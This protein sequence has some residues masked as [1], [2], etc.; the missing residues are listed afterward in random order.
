MWTCLERA[1]AKGPDDVGAAYVR[2]K[3]LGPEL[4]EVIEASVDPSAAISRNGRDM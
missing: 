3:L 4:S 2:A 1:G